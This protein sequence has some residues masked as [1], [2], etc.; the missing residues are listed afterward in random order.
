MAL[1][2]YNARALANF[3]QV[4][5]ITPNDSTVLGFGALYIGVSGDIAV[6]PIGQ[7]TSIVFKSCPVGILPVGVSRVLSTGTTASQILGLN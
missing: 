1:Q 7:T 2:P 3:G 4:T 6:I 5:A